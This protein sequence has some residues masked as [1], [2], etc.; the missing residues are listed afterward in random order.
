MYL[1][2]FKPFR[3]VR[4]VCYTGLA[5]LSAFYGAAAI[6]QFV[7]AAPRPSE[8]FVTHALSG[9]LYKADTLS[10]PIAGVG[11]GFDVLLFLLPAAAVSRLQLV[12]RRKLGVMA[13]FAIGFLYESPAC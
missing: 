6:T 10:I 4:L 7:F 3:W 5:A 1:H 12:R 9:E 13:L 11:L 2:I 8:T